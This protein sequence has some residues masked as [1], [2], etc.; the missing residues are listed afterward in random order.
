MVQNNSNDAQ[1][2]RNKNVE[3]D[4]EKE[5]EE[6]ED[7]LEE[8]YD[9]LPSNGPGLTGDDGEQVVDYDE[10]EE[11]EAFEEEVDDDDE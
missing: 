1:D 7:S 5:I 2:P 11:L 10:S 8:G 6:Q 9:I 4:H 3:S